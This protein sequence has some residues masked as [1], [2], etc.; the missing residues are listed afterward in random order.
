MDPLS[1]FLPAMRLASAVYTRLEASAPWA[2]DFD[3]YHHLKFGVILSGAC[4][5]RVQSAPQPVRLSAGDCYLLPR[6]NAFGLSDEPDRHAV[7]FNELLGRLQGRVLRYGGGGERAEIMGGRFIF[8]H[9]HT[10][11][12]LD[13]LP[14]MIHFRLSPSQLQ[15]LQL[16]L[17]LLAS[18]TTDPGMGAD[19]MVDRIAEIF[20]LQTLRAYI[21]EDKGQNVGWMG[22]A[23]DQQIG[24]A[25]RMVHEKLEQAWTVQSLALAVG[26]SRSV[27]AQRF[28]ALVGESP[29]E[30]L[31]RCRM[32]R[33]SRLLRESDLSIAQIAGLTGYDSDMSF[34]KAFKRRLGVTPGKYRQTVQ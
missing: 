9:Q 30:Y 3:A 11:P 23:T 4:W 26:M 6:G 28:K 29:M 15:A 34:S 2:I 1:D 16:T 8:A 33:A 7:N 31:A 21:N 22:A 25:L 12:L 17:Q 20:F 32:H 5:L 14:A 10:P 19:R 13:I 18:E 27:F 24:R